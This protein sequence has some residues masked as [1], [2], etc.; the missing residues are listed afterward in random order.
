MSSCS[1]Q[2]P[3]GISQLE[4][5]RQSGE[6]RVLTT[7]GPATFFNVSEMADDFEYQLAKSFAQ[8]LGVSLSLKTADNFSALEHDFSEKEIDLAAGTFRNIDDGKNV[9]FGPD[10]QSLS[11]QLLYKNTTAA[12]HNLSGLQRP[13][14][15][16]EESIAANFLNK[17]QAHL[18]N[19]TIA[20]HSSLST[21]QLIDMLWNETISYT[22]ADSNTV[23]IVQRYYP[24]L[25]TV[26]NLFPEITLAWSFPPGKDTSLTDAARAFFTKIKGNGQLKELENRYFNHIRAF[27]YVELK[28]FQKKIK[29]TLPDYYDYFINASQKEGIDWRLLAAIG[30]QESHWNPKAKSPTGVR[31]IMMLT[32]KTMKH[33]GITES[34]LNPEAS[35]TGGAIYFAQL[36]KRIPSQIREPD[37][38]WFALAAYNIGAGHLEDA[39]IL[40]EELGLN[41]NK[42]VDVK[43]KLPLLA[44]KKWYKKTRYGRARG[45]EA[46]KFVRNIRNYYDIMIWTSQHQPIIAKNE[47]G[48]S[49]N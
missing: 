19:L 31:G 13:V 1:Q 32:Q 11:L 48:L 2:T 39:R 33:L 38:T 42:W 9:N 21:L 45:K 4:R 35:I 47:G 49:E 43:E 24:E 36:K 6:I 27:D 22:V 15:I 28:R 8:Y 10:Y 44:I 41:P 5:I 37:R 14:D 3:S 17:Q 34:R 7:P 30:Y 29:N 18:P 46:I 12:P 16:L 20:Q 26:K 40:T 25:R 23:K